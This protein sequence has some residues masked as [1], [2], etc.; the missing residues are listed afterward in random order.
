M[1]LWRVTLADIISG[2]TAGI[3]KRRV[4]VRSMAPFH[5]V[6]FLAL[7]R[8]AKNC[9]SAILI[10]TLTNA[11]SAIM[12]GT[13]ITAEPIAA[14]PDYRGIIRDGAPAPMTKGAQVSELH[15]TSGGQPGDWMACVK[16]DTIPYV[17]LFAVFFEYGKVKDFRR[18]IGIDQCESAMYSPLPPAAPPAQE[19]D[20]PRK[21]NKIDS[22]LRPSHSAN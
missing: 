11:C 6:R 16:S 2:C 15:K 4:L 1:P 13:Q 3:S 8:N 10:A 9:F 12:G 21:H 14:P 22:T 7:N 17:G 18:S 19:K 5:H 20:K